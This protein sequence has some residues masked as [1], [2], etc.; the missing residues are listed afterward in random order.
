MSLP[1]F[2][3]H[4]AAV[5]ATIAETGLAVDIGAK[6]DGAGW[7]GASG[8]SDFVVYAIVYPLPGG[9][10]DGSVARPY[11]DATL[12][13][14]ITCVADT[15][16]AARQ[17]VDTVEAALVDGGITVAGRFVEPIEPAEAGGGIQRD[18]QTGDPPLFYATPRYD[19]TSRPA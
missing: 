7:Q 2:E 15:V 11:D 14:Q 5:A 19:I 16:S 4:D 3:A 10:R 18:D 8:E 17:V 6:P 13:Y 12:P 9:S 1:L